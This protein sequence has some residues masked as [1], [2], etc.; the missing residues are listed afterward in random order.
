MAL[1]ASLYLWM[2]KQ[3]RDRPGFY[4]DGTDEH[5]DLPHQHRL[6]STTHGR[7]MQRG[8]QA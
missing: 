2:D 6:L 8:P 7:Q 3:E 1:I 5:A 4:L